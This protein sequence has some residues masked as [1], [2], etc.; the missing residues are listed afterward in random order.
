ETHRADWR[1]TMMVPV[2]IAFVVLLV[3]GIL[4]DRQSQ[5]IAETRLRS[6][7]LVELSVIRAQLEGNIAGDIQLVKGLVSVIAT[8]PQMSQT[9]FAALVQSLFEKGS[10]LRSIAAAPDLVVRMTYPLQANRAVI[11]FDYR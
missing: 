9:R 7:A 2:L 4:I 10:Q 11:G 6:Q 5:Q 3:A 8:E 1:R